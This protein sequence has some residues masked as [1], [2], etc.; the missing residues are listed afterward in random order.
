[1]PTEAS[2]QIWDYAYKIGKIQGTI[3]AFNKNNIRSVSALREIER[4][5]NE[6]MESEKMEKSNDN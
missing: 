3:S 2:K 1:M 4:I 5:C 6:P